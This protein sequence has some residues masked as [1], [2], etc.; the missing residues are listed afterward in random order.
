[1]DPFATILKF[2]FGEV[3]FYLIKTEL[4]VF[5]KFNSGF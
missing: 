1:M 3:Y 2:L 5:N 4:Q